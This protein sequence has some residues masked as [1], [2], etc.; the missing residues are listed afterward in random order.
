MARLAFL[1][2]AVG[3]AWRPIPAQA[4]DARKPISQY[5][6]S[7]WEAQAGLPQSSVYAIAQTPD[8]FLW[9]ATQEGVA[10][11]DG[12]RFT[13]F[14]T[15]N[16]PAFQ[17]NR[18]NDLMVDSRGVL[19]IGT[20]AGLIRFSN[21]SFAAFTTKEGLPHNAVQSVY[22]DRARTLWIGTRRGLSRL[23]R[24][25]LR[26][27][28]MAALAG[29]RVLA[30][31]ADAGGA[32]WIGT[33]AG[34]WRL[35]GSDA[36]RI[37]IP[38]DRDNPLIYAIQED[39]RHRLWIGG[40]AGLWRVSG[41]KFERMGAASDRV[42][43]LLADHGGNLWIGTYGAGLTRC[44]DAGARLSPAAG[45]VGL[46][47]AV[48]SALYEDREGNLWVGTAGRGLHRFRDGRFSVFGAPEGVSDDVVRSVLQDRSGT[49]WI[50]TIGG[51]SK[52]EPDGTVKSYGVKDGLS[53]PRVWGMTEGRDGSLWVG[54]DGGGLNRLLDD[55]FSALT[56]TD[57]LSSNVVRTVLEDRHGDVWIGTEAGL[58]RYHDG[59]VQT[60][61]GAIA[62]AMIVSLHEDRAGAIWIGTRGVGLFQYRDGT[63]TAFT[64][65]NG[66]SSN[67]ISAAMYEDADGVLWVGTSGFGLNRFKDGRFVT[68]RKRDGLFD[69]SLHTLVEDAVGN[70][71]MSSNKGVWS[72]TKRA[73]VEQADGVTRSLHSVVYG[74][75]DGLRSTEFN[76]GTQ[77]SG[78]R[79]RTGR[80]WFATMKGV[81]VIDPARIAL[82]AVP[83]EIVFENVRLDGRRATDPRALGPGRGDLEFEYTALSFV[84]PEWI[85]FRY[86]LEGFDTDWIDA[87]TR[88]KAYYT[89]VPPGRYVFRVAAANSDGVWN[90]VGV[91]TPIVLLPHVYQTIWFYG[92]CVVGVLALVGGTHGLRIHRLN[93]RERKLQALV[94]ERTKE[95][96]AAHGIAEA[97][98]EVA[99]AANRSKSEFLANMSHEIRTPMNGVL[100]MT[101]LVLDTELDP[102]QR[103]YLEMAR[104]SADS[105]LTTIND[106]LDFSKIEAGRV[107]LD[108]GEFD[109]RENIFT[110]VKTLAVRA[111]QKG[112]ELVC[113][114][115]SDVPARLVG[116]ASRLSQVLINLVGNA[117]KFTESGL[118]AVRATATPAKDGTVQ[119]RYAVED[120]GVGVPDALKTHIFEPFKQAD[121]S[122]TRKYGGTGLGLSISARLV[123]L[124]GG[125]LSVES[126]GGHGA[127]FH[128]TIPCAV[129]STVAEAEP[130][131]PAALAGVRVLVAD[132][133]VVSRQVL[134]GILKRW[135]MCPFSVD[136]GDAALRMQDDASRC[137]EPFPLALL[138]ARMPRMDGFSVADRIRGD[139]DQACA[140]ILML[141]S[142]DRVGDA[143][144]CRRLGISSCLIKPMRPSEL[145]AAICTALG[146]APRSTAKEPMAKTESARPAHLRILL[147][148]DNRVNQTLAVA[149]L[150]RDGHTVTV[151]DNGAEAAAVA[152]T[153]R[154]DAILMDIQMPTM[155]GLEATAMIRADEAVKGGHVPIIAITAH[156]MSGDRD[157]CL[158]AGMDD[159]VAKPIALDDLRRVLERVWAAQSADGDPSSDAGAL[160]APESQR[161]VR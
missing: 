45:G 36:T 32:T 83:P 85:V 111:H 150:R 105:L 149:L 151:V 93:E 18:V 107:D 64:T 33:D 47:N 120:T 145:L 61:S 87:G 114:V 59:K 8:G 46:D 88:R 135:G 84:T 139:G 89:K 121:G 158:G 92:L 101:A 116:D 132:D 70:V 48:V 13:V 24:Q 74:I 41:E 11:F 91:S 155:G 80:V 118:V 28:T 55:R 75:D 57:G 103:E 29:A 137:G 37:P 30:I 124:M 38:G 72:V 147:A 152:T 3:A 141:T 20:E 52:L 126:V 27:E 153:R 131:A 49:L 34:L 60:F 21:G 128:F 98:R 78:W 86:K 117:V 7:A 160:S 90:E 95:L 44:C 10:R 58:N 136:S 2:A 25:T 154:F 35:A 100:G 76:G 110:T 1:V 40:D 51:L 43:S 65:A 4:L 77:P 125:T 71:W 82:N 129:G 50:G 19:W 69:D 106:I 144:R 115:A 56:T 9:I 22:E 15:D 5:V 53:Y 130:S 66:L 133:N 39:T 23:D 26:F 31:H 156:A 54:T 73:L 12:V 159:Y 68:I 96:E 67:A 42:R 146:S 81:V 123:R 113:D 108:P 79:D 140:T 97:A 127:T 104:T 119:L 143:G 62:T 142:D 17:T 109:V 122:T 102:V 63:F 16:T 148:E 94:K 112:L 99:E 138:D 134:E 161:V 14:D 6:H 157:L